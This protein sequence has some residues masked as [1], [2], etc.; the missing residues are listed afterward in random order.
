MSNN[1]IRIAIVAIVKGVG[2]GAIFIGACVVLI[3]LVTVLL[4]GVSTGD[5]V[6]RVTVRLPIYWMLIGWA[7]AAGWV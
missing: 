6:T 4:H 7:A 1:P 2:F 3:T 5:F